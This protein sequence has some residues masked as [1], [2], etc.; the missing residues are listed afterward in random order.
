MLSTLPDTAEAYSDSYASISLEQNIRQPRHFPSETLDD[1]RPTP[2]EGRYASE[3]YWYAHGSEAVQAFNREARALSDHQT[4]EH[5][6]RVGTLTCYIALRYGERDTE[7][8]KEMAIGAFIHDLGKLRHR[9]QQHLYKGEL[10][11]REFQDIMQ[12]PADGLEHPIA[13]GISPIARD[14]IG[15]HHMYKAFR[16]YGASLQSVP[17]SL[18]YTVGEQFATV[19]DVYDSLRSA[20]PSRHSIYS[21]MN[22]LALIQKDL[23][24]PQSILQALGD[25]VLPAPQTTQL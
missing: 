11:E 3:L 5:T 4:L 17:V 22:A 16:P 15:F 13:Q 9:S 1:L 12:H 2:E 25:L 24:V 21:T 10:S 23:L 20:R 19:A 8:L 14:I 6:H 18:R 7:K